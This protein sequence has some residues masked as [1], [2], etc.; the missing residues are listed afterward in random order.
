[1]LRLFA[2]PDVARVHSIRD[3]LGKHEI[4]A[5][6]RGD[7]ASERQ[8]RFKEVWPS[9]W[10]EQDTDAVHAMKLISSINAKDEC[11]NKAWTCKRCSS[12][13]PAGTAHCYTCIEREGEQRKERLKAAQ[14]SALLLVKI[15]AAF[16][17]AFIV[18]LILLEHF[19]DKETEQGLF[20]FAGISFITSIVLVFWAVLEFNRKPE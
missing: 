15:A 14:A 8:A 7:K 16:F 3:L 1:M 10:I 11:C 13:N 20:T 17:I 18:A 4:P 6:V 2:A 5:V 9:V 19:R 12:L